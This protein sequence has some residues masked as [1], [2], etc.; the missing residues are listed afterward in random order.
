MDQFSSNLIDRLPYMY[1]TL[2]IEFSPSY[3]ALMIFFQELWPFIEFVIL[4]RYSL[5]RLFGGCS[6]PLVLLL[7]VY[8]FS[9]Q[10]FRYNSIKRATLNL[11]HL[12]H[13]RDTPLLSSRA[14]RDIRTLSLNFEGEQRYRR[15]G[16]ASAPG[17]LQRF[18]YFNNLLD[19]FSE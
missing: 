15:P 9:P 2:F 5:H 12:S 3:C 14:E 10:L 6:R 11:R 4:G 19:C 7:V 17:T 8:I 16:S 18:L 13:N 1:Y